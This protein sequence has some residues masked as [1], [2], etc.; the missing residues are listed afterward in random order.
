MSIAYRGWGWCRLPLTPGDRPGQ[1]D[2]VVEFI[3]PDSDLAKA[4]DKEFW[5]RKEVERPKFSANRV[6]EEV[7]KAG[8]PKFR[9]HHDHTNMWKA[10]NAKEP[11]KG[12][13]V[14]VE[15]AWFWYEPWIKRCIELCEKAGDRYR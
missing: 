15:K 6:V 13:G 8:F 3:D 2:R 5:V 4:I 9:V 12:Y 11:G 10:D 1:A 7:R 14:Q